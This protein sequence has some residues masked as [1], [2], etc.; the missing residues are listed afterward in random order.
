MPSRF[1]HAEIY[2]EDGKTSFYVYPETKLDPPIAFHTVQ[3]NIGPEAAYSQVMD[4]G[5]VLRPFSA[6]LS[7]VVHLE[8][9]SGKPK[10]HQDNAIGEVN[11]PY[12]F[13]SFTAVQTLHVSWQF[14]KSVAHTT[15][16]EYLDDHLMETT[17]VLS[18]LISVFLEGQNTETIEKLSTTLRADGRSVIIFSDDSLNPEGSGLNNSS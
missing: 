2:I 18:A 16:E 4:M 6:I 8:I 7:D 5:E 9:K 1:R 14:A 11:W 15:F 10:E 13:H 12:L 17:P 3:P